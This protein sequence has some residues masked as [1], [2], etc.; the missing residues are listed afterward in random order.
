MTNIKTVAN[1]DVPMKKFTFKYSLTTLLL[2]PIFV[3]LGF[4][5]L[6]RYHEK[7]A[8]QP[9]LENQQDLKI[10]E[11]QEITTRIPYRYRQLTVTGHFLNTHPIYLDNQILKGQIGYRIMTPFKPIGQA[12]T[13]L[14]DRGWIPAGNNRDE[15]PSIK[16][17]FGKQTLIGIINLP[18]NSLQ[19]PKLSHKNIDKPFRVQRIDFADLSFLLSQPLYPFILQ[20]HPND[21]RGFNIQPITFN[22]PATRHLAYAIQ[23]VTMALAVLVYYIVINRY[24]CSHT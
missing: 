7:I 15:L 21:P 12:N 2:I 6:D 18:S 14:I 9:M 17:V 19:L 22:T 23:W 16:P 10:L 8:S 5:Q 11:I 13:L 24:R 3:Y 1:V 20:L 4:W